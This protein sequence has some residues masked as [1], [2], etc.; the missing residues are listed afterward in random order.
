MATSSAADKGKPG[1][2][3]IRSLE[4]ALRLLEVLSDGESWKLSQ[5][6]QELGLN[7]STAYRLLITLL[8]NDY[9]ERDNASGGYRL[10]LACL[11]LARSY[12]GVTSVRMRCRP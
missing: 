4:R 9:I 12:T 6:S 8:E 2:Y 5:L 11:E 10:G 7:S 1:R 3:N